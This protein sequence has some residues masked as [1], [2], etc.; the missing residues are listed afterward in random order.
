MIVDLSIGG[1]SISWHDIRIKMGNTESSKRN[2]TMF[3]FPCYN[4][5]RVALIKTKHYRNK[6]LHKN[7]LISLFIYKAIRIPDNYQRL[8][9]AKDLILNIYFFLLMEK[10]N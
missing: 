7:H 1:G 9:I 2:I 4:V 3:F 5:L 6:L 8:Y 10:S